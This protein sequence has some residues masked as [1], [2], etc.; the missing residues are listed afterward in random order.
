ML[1]EMLAPAY[2]VFVCLCVNAQLRLLS[3]F[4]LQFIRRNRRKVLD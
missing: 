2:L 3:G 4:L 1:N